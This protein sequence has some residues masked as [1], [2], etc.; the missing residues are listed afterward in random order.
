MNEPSALPAVGTYVD[1]RPFW[2]GIAQ[3]RLVLQYCRDA[4]RFQHYPRPVSIFTGR[5]N[6]EWRE[7]S[8]LGT[9]YAVTVMRVP[10]LGYAGKPPYAVATVELDEGVRMI[11]RIL[12][13]AAD[14]VR[15]GMRVRVAWEP[16]GEG[17]YPAFEPVPGPA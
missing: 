15:V 5:R 9:I 12:G 3:R 16:L 7:V 14:G 4:G 11:A 8:G 13:C 2:E 6:L 17:V 10:G 1:S